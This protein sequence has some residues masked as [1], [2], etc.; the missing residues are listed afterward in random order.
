[1]PKSSSA[2]F[3]PYSLRAM[4]FCCSCEV[5][6]EEVLSVISKISSSRGNEYC[7]MILLQLSTK[8][9]AAKVSREKLQEIK[10]VSIPSLTSSSIKAQTFSKE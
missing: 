3:T 5:F 7:P 10:N 9:A 4:A 6:L 2:I 8:S 1:M